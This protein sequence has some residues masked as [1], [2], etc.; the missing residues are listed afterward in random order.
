VKTKQQVID[1]GEAAKRLLE[2]TD[3]KRF[4]AEIEQDCWEEFKATNTSDSSAR[5][6]VY[7][8]LRGVELVQQALRAMADNA[9]IEKRGK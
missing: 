9:A 4:L 1:D 3:L 8:K 7:M 6:A 2:D 5:E